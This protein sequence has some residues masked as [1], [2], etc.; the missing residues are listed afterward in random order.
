[1]AKFS[2]NN[3]KKIYIQYIWRIYL[4]IIS[5]SMFS[6]K[7]PWLSKIKL[8]T[9]LFP[10]PHVWFKFW[11][12]SAGKTWKF[13][14]GLPTLSAK[15]NMSGKPVSLPYSGWGQEICSG[16]E[17]KLSKCLFHFNQIIHL[18]CYIQVLGWFIR[19]FFKDAWTFESHCMCSDAT[20]RI[21]Y[22]FF[23]RVK[24]SVKIVCYYF[25]FAFSIY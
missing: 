22:V 21:Q 2:E 12:D 14:N 16:T 20:R 5:E 1:M 11:M 4:F 17:F 3:I 7:Q 15:L 6:K 10:P 19:P 25:Y 13:W 9:A 24:L 18:K 8:W 23:V